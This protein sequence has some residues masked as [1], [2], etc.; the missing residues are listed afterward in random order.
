MKGDS[1]MKQNNE[2]LEEIEFTSQPTIPITE[3]KKLKGIVSHDDFYSRYILPDKQSE[4]WDKSII[5]LLTKPK[6]LAFVLRQNKARLNF[7]ETNS[8]FLINYFGSNDIPDKQKLAQ[9][10]NLK[11]SPEVQNIIVDGNNLIIVKK[12]GSYMSSSILSKTFDWLGGDEKLQSSSRNKDSHRSTLALAKKLPFESTVVTGKVAG[13]TTKS[14]YLHSWLEAIVDGKAVVI[15]YT[16]NAIMNKSGYYAL[17]QASSISRIDS[18]NLKSDEELISPLRES[19][20]LSLK[21]YLIY[22]DA[23][24]SALENEEV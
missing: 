19:K 24:I 21:E 15:D 4:E 13:L 5:S 18:Y 9:L 1:F 17:R 23:I 14:S 12:D 22:R 11:T 10:R 3:S 20:Q 16:M 7:F 8:L 6:Q 2:Y